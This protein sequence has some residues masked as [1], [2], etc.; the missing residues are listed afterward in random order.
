MARIAREGKTGVVK[1]QRGK[2]AKELFFRRGWLLFGRSNVVNE[3]LGRILTDVGKI[4]QEELDLC[5]ARMKAE[6]KR[7][8]EILIEMELL[9]PDDVYFALKY[10]LKRRAIDVISW[11]EGQFQFVEGVELDPTITDVTRIPVPALLYEG[12]KEI[13]SPEKR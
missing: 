11:E 2:I 3:C 1:L 8:G 7:Q 9:S 6:K 5:L 10:Q 13:Y 12:I 4:T